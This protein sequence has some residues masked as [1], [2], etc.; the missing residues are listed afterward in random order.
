MRKKS[1][2]FQE[3]LKKDLPDKKK[4]HTFAD[5]IDLVKKFSYE[6]FDAT[7]EVHVKTGIDTRKNDQIV[8][9]SVVLP[10][11]TGKTKKIA[12]FA[13][14]E[15][16][17]EARDAGA[18]L[19]G[20]AELIAEIKQTSKADFDVAIATPDMMKSL[21]GIA[22]VLGPRGLM[23]SPKN[24]TVT[25]NI[26]GAISQVKK[27]KVDFKND[28]SGNVHQIIGKRSFT[29]EQLLEN[30]TAFMEIL[31][32]ARPSATKGTFLQNISL[33]TTMGPGIRV[34]PQ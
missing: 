15:K 30:Y 3:L 26:K 2:K 27:G 18:D 28:D 8:R 29:K 23:P 1:K 11:G 9:G 13:E 21:A 16:A 31:R 17:T 6:Q 33:S 24:E 5:A 10:Y 14:G 19:V 4:L 20:G 34:T 32:K 12:V 22:K 7:V 25:V